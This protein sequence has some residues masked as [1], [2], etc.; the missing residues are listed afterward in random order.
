[1]DAD[2]VGSTVLEAVGVWSRRESEGSLSP[3]AVRNFIECWHR[4]LGRTA[5]AWSRGDVDDSAPLAKR[6][7]SGSD[8][9]DGGNASASNSSDARWDVGLSSVDVPPLFARVMLGRGCNR[10]QLIRSDGQPRKRISLSDTMAVSQWTQ[11][12]SASAFPRQAHI[13]ALVHQAGM[14]PR[15]SWTGD[16]HS[17]AVGTYSAT[18]TGTEPRAEVPPA[19]AAAAAQPIGGGKARTP[20]GTPMVA[21]ASLA[22]RPPT[23]TSAEGARVDTRVDN[24]ERTDESVAKELVVEESELY[25]GSNT[26]IAFFESVQRD[27]GGMKCVFR[28]GVLTVAAPEGEGERG[29][30]AAG[31]KRSSKRVRRAAPAA[32]AAPAARGVAAVDLDVDEPD[33]NWANGEGSGESDVGGDAGGG[34]TVAAAHVDGAGSDAAEHIHFIVERCDADLRN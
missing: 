25:A 21:A 2:I 23:P 12:A 4:R 19:A 16:A 9:D 32:A 28:H 8:S 3:R 33:Y 5:A 18:R 13:R 30:A 14:L 11:T 26:L 15:A 10:S 24:A 27:K 31:A 34:L 17:A 20:M 1:M 29:A 22:T 6:H 7:R